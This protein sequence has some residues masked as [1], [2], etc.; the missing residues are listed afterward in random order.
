MPL[1][2]VIDP[3]HN[4]RAEDEPGRLPRWLPVDDLLARAATADPGWSPWPYELLQAAVGE[5]QERDYLSTSMFSGC[6]RGTV[7]ERREPF[8]YSVDEMYAALRGTLT[9]YALQYA[10][11]PNSLAEAR[12]WTTINIKGLREPIEL[13]CSPDIITWNPDGLGD[14]K[15]T[16]NP[17]QNNYPWVSHKN[18]VFSNQWLVRHAERWALDGEPFDLPFNP[19]E[20]QPTSLYL[21]YLGPKG[22]KT[23]EVKKTREVPNPKNTGMVKRSLPYIP[24]DEEVEAMLFPKVKAMAQALA[25][26][27]EWPFKDDEEPAGFTGPPGWA[28]PG[29]PWCSLPGCLAKRYPGGMFWEAA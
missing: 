13:S 20:W 4:E 11:R 2:G 16:E 21:V 23:L 5:W 3:S 7:L 12:F 9:H 28:C 25:A 15:V 18:Q 27:P 24:D 8:I 6:G 14:Y 29:K 26:Y 10:H 19:R 22:P 1:V 17:P